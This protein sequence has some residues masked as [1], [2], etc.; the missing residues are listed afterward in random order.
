MNA[1]GRVGPW[2]VALLLVAGCARSGF[3]GDS[4]D[5]V[6]YSAGD[7]GLDHDLDR[8]PDLDHRQD[9]D[10]GADFATR[11]SAP[12]SMVQGKQHYA[13]AAD[14]TQY[15][16]VWVEY[17]AGSY[18]RELLF[19]TVSP[20][21]EIIRAPERITGLTDG[22]RYVALLEG[23]G[24]FLLFY[25]LADKSELEI[26]RLLTAGP[27]LEVQEVGDG[28]SYVHLNIFAAQDGPGAVFIRTTTC[29][30]GD[31]SKYQVY[32]RRFDRTGSPLTEVRGPLDC[33]PDTQY[34][35]KAVWTGSHYVVVWRDYRSG[36]R[37]Y[38]ARADPELGLLGEPA[39][40]VKN[41]GATQ[42]SPS[43]V[44]DGQGRLLASWEESGQLL[45]I[46][47]DDQGQPVWDDT[48]ELIEGNRLE[49]LD[50]EMA[51]G[52]GRVALVWE[53]DRETVLTQ[54]RLATLKPAELAGPPATFESRVI[55]DPRFAFCCPR[56]ARGPA[57]FGVVYR[58]AVEG[59]YGLFFEE[60]AD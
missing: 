55:S 48:H 24:G 17:P 41:H 59:G 60:V 15:G 47:L 52:D 43:L 26:L 1:S 46:L 21:G 6:P 11:L 32:L 34:Y 42:Y 16:V 27:T 36:T 50:H 5:G 33:H 9:G 37:S 3:R 44:W 56:I 2:A 49:S 7:S 10:Q 29:A 4:P 23:E 39:A 30:S 40:P 57:G 31:P 12:T 53:S 28:A 20:A 38:L 25:Q 13:I 51:G 45:H 8:D 54:I 19:A 18:Q 22:L 58:G 14:D 35:P